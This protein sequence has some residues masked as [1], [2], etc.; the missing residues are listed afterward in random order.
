MSGTLDL[1]GQR[2]WVVGAGGG[3]IGTAMCSELS[4][5]GAHVIAIDRDEAALAPTLDA[6]PGPVSVEVLDAGDRDELLAMA[7]RCKSAHGP[8]TGLVNVVGGLPRD[9]WGRIAELAD[10]AF[11]AVMQLNLRCAWNA[12]RVFARERIDAGGG[13]AIVQLT[14]IAALQ[15]MPFGAAYAAAKAALISLTRTMA[16]EWGPHGVRVN[17]LAAG[18]VRVPRSDEDEPSRDAAV[19]P[20]GRRGQPGDIAG[21]ARFLLSELAGWVTGQVLVVDGGA[22]IRPGYLDED[23]LPVFVS[24]PE[25]RAGLLEDRFGD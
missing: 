25:F 5:A 24:D 3:G 21:A 20:L 8:P 6:C 18:S 14:S 4:R 7:A 10:E 15:A 22:S 17:A 2:V 23:S 12:S 1:E 13:G 19:I 16:L 9:R 11:D